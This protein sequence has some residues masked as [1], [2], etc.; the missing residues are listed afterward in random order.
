MSH[1][2]DYP[3]P[4]R[5]ELPPSLHN[6][7]VQPS[8]ALL[9]IHNMQDDL[10]AL[11][12]ADTALL[13]QVLSHLQRLRQWAE[14]N[15]VPVLYTQ[16]IQAGEAVPAPLLA[17]LKAHDGAAKLNKS[18]LSSFSD[19]QLLAQ[20]QDSQRDQLLLAGAD[21][22]GALLATAI[23]AADQQLQL[24]VV[25][26]ALLAGSR[27]EHQLAL[28]Y[29]AQHCGQLLLCASLDADASEQA[30]QTL[31]TWLGERVLQLI[32]DE[33]QLDPQENLI[34]YGLDS[35]QVMKIAGEL[36]ERGVQVSFDELA[37]SPTLAHWYQLIGQRL[38]ATKA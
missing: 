4:A 17:Q 12:G 7:S 24:F 16:Q 25:A 20:L 15:Q 19:G 8:R 22:Y 23:A 31:C 6:H 5:S 37:R 29:M 3:L 2:I 35:L 36:K 26:D 30:Q 33:D 27:D 21:A 28:K 9:L 13:S 14:D 18:T 34:F 32:E 11:Y 38:A 10:L 1:V